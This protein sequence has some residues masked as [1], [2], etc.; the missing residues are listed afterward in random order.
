MTSLK[1]Q[2]SQG[3]AKP[4]VEA[5]AA[6]KGAVSKKLC[7]TEAANQS[8]FQNGILRLNKMNT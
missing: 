3:P 8:G 7:L 6:G 1:R 4:G 5:P 2:V